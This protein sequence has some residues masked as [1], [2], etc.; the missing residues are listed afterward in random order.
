MIDQDGVH[1]FPR[2]APH[3]Q[4]Q[5]VVFD[6][7]RQST[8]I[9]DLD[10]MLGGGLPTG[11]TTLITG[12]TG[13]GKSLLGLNWLISG[14]QQKERAMLVTFEQYPEQIINNA[15][16]F[17]YNLDNL[18]Q[19]ELLH[20]LHVSPVE[21]DVDY[22]MAR[23]QKMVTER[24]IKRLLIDSISAFE[25]GMADKYKFTDYIWGL[26]NYF[27]TQGVSVVLINEVPEL[28]HA[29]QL[30]KHGISFIADNII[31]AQLVQKDFTLHRLLGV[32]KVRGSRCSTEIKELVLGAEGPVL[33]RPHWSNML[34]VEEA[35][36]TVTSP[37][38]NHLTYR[39]DNK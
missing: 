2:L 25:I 11:T 13:T 21:L 35:A 31:A 24:K 4:K 9:P 33:V 26:A 23:V 14:T 16:A 15:C 7:E 19:Q 27:K 39:G 20:I 30:S 18:I 10:D 29:H 3:V 34:S 6:G 32:I 38:M 37:D 28:F 17:G 36:P 8:G 5:A 22:H 1:V 12:C